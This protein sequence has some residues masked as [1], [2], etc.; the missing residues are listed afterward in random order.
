MRKGY[1]RAVIDGMHATNSEWVACIAKI[2][3]NIA[4]SQLFHLVGR[5]SLF[6]SIQ[7]VSHKGL[8]AEIHCKST[9]ING[10]TAKINDRCKSRVY[11]TNEL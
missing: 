8:T 10:G 11:M 1:S 5:I 6:V 2:K 9:Y 3:P 7:S 4:A